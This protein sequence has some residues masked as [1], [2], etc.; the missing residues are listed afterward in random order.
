MNGTGTASNFVEQ[1]PG[2][3]A[4]PN[5]DPRRIINPAMVSTAPTPQSLLP[6]PFANPTAPGMITMNDQSNSMRG[7]GGGAARAG[8]D[9]FAASAQ[10]YQLTG[11]MGGSRRYSKNR[12]DDDQIK[13]K[14]PKML[15]PVQ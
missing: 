4:T 10:P 5:Y 8:E 12:G 6:N 11:T 15:T 7:G 9:V 14:T 1:V 2:I 13:R 3:A